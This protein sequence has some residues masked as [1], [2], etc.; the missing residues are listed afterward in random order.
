[1]G[2]VDLQGTGETRGPQLALKHLIS[3]HAL[4]LEPG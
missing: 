1:M 3:S 2:V 4:G